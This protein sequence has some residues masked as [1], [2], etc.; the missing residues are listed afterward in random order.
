MSLDHSDRR[1]VRVI[2]WT[3]LAMLAIY[4]VA[5]L[6]LPRRD[7]DLI[8][9]D[10]KHHFVQL[11]SVVFDGDLDFR[12]EFMGRYGVPSADPE[13][14]WLVTELT[15]T[16]H[17]RNFMPVGPALLWA[18][19][20]L[21]AAGVQV[22]L[23]RAGLAPAPDGFDLPL[24]L[25]PGV[26]GIAAATMAAWLA[27]RMARRWTHPASA[28]TGAMGIWLGSHALYYC[29]VS[30]AYSHAA[31]MLTAALLFV[32]WQGTAARPSVGRFAV[33]GALAGAC[34]L[35]RWQDAMFVVVPAIELLRWR[36]G[37][38]PRLAAAA[39]AGTAW[40]AVFSPQMV[41][42]QVLYGEA[43]TVPQGPSFLE[44]T[45][46]NL[47][48]VLFSDNHGLLTW[49][50]I[51]IL[52]AIGGAAVLRRHRALMPV[53]VPV[54]LL[55][56]YLNAAVADWWAGEAFGARRF[57]SL[58]PLFVVGLA[59]WS[60]GAVGQQPSRGRM[61]TIAAFA[62]ANWLLLLQYQLFMKGLGD[63]SPYPSGWF[64]MWIVRVL[65]PFRLLTWWTP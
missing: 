25:V 9:G 31:S 1:A 26:T 28:L 50:P 19:L 27:Y 30:P 5:V 41:V 6:V 39:A 40:L 13:A 42:W 18:P 2:A 37:W 16:G 63:L 59:A 49:A 51:L 17:V 15:P 8:A 44:W 55:A 4:V 65:V 62:A 60:E 34:A 14:D 7:G 38:R 10:A 12:N 46:P 45:S 47:V 29:L 53:L 3:G 52:A 48:A 64:D 20:Y 61:L 11:R 35:M 21:L 23:A 32:W 22:L 33:G 54:V 58:F 56:W 36:A 24:Q 43:F 57:L